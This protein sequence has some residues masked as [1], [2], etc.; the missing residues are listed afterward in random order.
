M[1]GY[2]IC[3]NNQHGLAH[4]FNVFYEALIRVAGSTQ[5]CGAQL[6]S[7]IKKSRV[8]TKEADFYPPTL[9]PSSY[10]V[11]DKKDPKVLVEDAAKRQTVY[12]IYVNA[13][14]A[15]ATKYLNSQP[16]IKNTQTLMKT[17][18]V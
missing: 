7:S 12:S 16:K 14:A 6:K 3:D 2:V 8:L 4:Q 13:C 10:S 11:P 17:S 15:Q 5:K 9:D 1:K 18:L